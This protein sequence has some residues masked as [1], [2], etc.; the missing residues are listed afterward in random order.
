MFLH[1]NYLKK[2][3]NYSRTT[4]GARRSRISVCRALL[5]TMVYSL[6]GVAPTGGEIGNPLERQ[7]MNP[8]AKSALGCCWNHCNIRLWRLRSTPIYYP[9]DNIPPKTAGTVSLEGDNKVSEGSTIAPSVYGDIWV[10]QR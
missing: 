4:S 9:Y 5:W 2:F 8:S 3:V 10:L 7:L 1:F 6:L